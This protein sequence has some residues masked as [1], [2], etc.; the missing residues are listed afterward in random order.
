MRLTTR[1]NFLD[2]FYNS[3]YKYELFC[4]IFASEGT[5]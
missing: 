2:E 3:L 1:I 5:F 4:V